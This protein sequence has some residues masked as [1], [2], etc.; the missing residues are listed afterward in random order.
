M[1]ATPRCSAA[2]AWKCHGGAT[3]RGFS[4]QAR[5]GPHP[6]PGCPRLLPWSALP[7]RLTPA[8]PRCP[9]LAFPRPGPALL[10][11][12][13]RLPH[14]AGRPGG[15]RALG[16]GPNRRHSSRIRRCC[17]GQLRKRKVDLTDDD[18]DVMRQVVESVEDCEA[19]RPRSGARND[20]ERHSL[21]MVGHDPMRL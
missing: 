3:S 4:S 10:G 14:G 9:G 6:S 11:N 5:A 21:M 19:N 20:R 8:V 15:L 2:P 17:T 16:A 7:R 18:A 13:R 12:A 1:S